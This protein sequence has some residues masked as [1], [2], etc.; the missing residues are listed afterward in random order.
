[1]LLLLEPEAGAVVLGAMRSVCTPGDRFELS[2]AGRTAIGSLAVLGLGGSEPD[3]DTLPR[4]TPLLLGATLS[5]ATQAKGTIVEILAIGA[6]IDETLD[7]AR[8]DQVLLFADALGHADHWVE[9]L[10]ASRN[11]DLGPVI[12]DM[13]DRN[14][15]SVT[16]GRVNLADVDDINHWLLPYEDNGGDPDLVRRYQDLATLQPGTFGHEFWA[17][18][19]RHGFAFPGEPGAVNEMFATPH[20]CAH[21]L[22]GYDTTPQGELLVSTFTSRMHPIFP[23]E[24][25]VLPVI[26]T[27]HLGIEFNQLAGS[28]RGALDPAKFWVAWDRGLQTNDDTFAI[29][30]DLWRC[31]GEPLD[32][33]RQRFG[34]PPLDA[35]HAAESDAVPGVDYQPIA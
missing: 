3:V 14:L 1:M 35:V 8:I 25:H 33:V 11:P 19:D 23:M 30:F 18:Y 16:D 31:A 15:R 4:T 27:W 10:A 9:D 29:D 6:L 28:Y 2:V 32:V 20:D 34:V 22:S 24:G 7:P 13:G 26:F 5:D 21:L 12:A 17:F